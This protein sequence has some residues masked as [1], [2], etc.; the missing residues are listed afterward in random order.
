MGMKA[1]NTERTAEPMS[2]MAANN[3]VSRVLENWTEVGSSLPNTI[4][5]TVSTE[6]KHG[7]S[8]FSFMFSCCSFSSY[9]FYKNQPIQNNVHG[10]ALV[11]ALVIR[12]DIESRRRKSMTGN[13]KGLRKILPKK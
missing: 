8:K 7:Y 2:E 10:L 1:T 4:A 12:P 13:R 9:H 5:S 6:M 3:F 11:L